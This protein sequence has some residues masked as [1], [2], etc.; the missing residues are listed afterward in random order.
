MKTYLAYGFALAL[1][2]LLIAVLLFFL[3]FHSDAEKIPTGQAIGTVGNIVIYATCL[4][5]GIKA[6][7]ADVPANQ[8]FGYGRALG[9]GVMIALFGALFTAITHLIYIN[10][11]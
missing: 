9:A 5:L 8:D 3:G 1:G 2:G 4:V 11:I 10:I 6:R 7:R